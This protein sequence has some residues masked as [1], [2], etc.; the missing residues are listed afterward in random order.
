ML[1]EAK[2]SRRPA[3]AEC[4]LYLSRAVAAQGAFADEQNGCCGLGTVVVLVV[5]MFRTYGSSGLPQRLRFPRIADLAP[6]LPHGWRHRNVIRTSPLTCYPLQ[7]R[8]SPSIPSVKHKLR[9]EQLLL[10]PDLF[11]SLISLLLHSPSLSRPDFVDLL[12]ILQGGMF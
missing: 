10:S 5:L 2:P 7:Y 3:A 1:L 12:R 9:R 8:K 11:L 4:V 6:A